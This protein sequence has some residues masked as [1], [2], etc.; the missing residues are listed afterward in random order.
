MG[1]DPLRGRALKGFIM[2]MIRLCDRSQNGYNSGDLD[3][4]FTLLR[5]GQV[6]DGSLPSKSSRSYFVKNGYAVA[7]EGYTSLT[8]KGLW[9][10]LTSWAGLSAAYHHWRRWKTNPFIASES[11]QKNA[12]A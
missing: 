1:H 8:G 10:L 5:C 4:A 12:E 2:R 7:H 9:S 6:S 3:T 11:E